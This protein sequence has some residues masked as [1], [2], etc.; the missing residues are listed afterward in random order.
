MIFC[1]TSRPKKSLLAHAQIVFALMRT[2]LDKTIRCVLAAFLVVGTIQW[3]FAGSCEKEQAH[4]LGTHAEAAAPCA[5][6]DHHVVSNGAC[7]Q[8]FCC[9][10]A[11]CGQCVNGVTMLQSAA[12]R[13][14]QD[15]PSVIPTSHQQRFHQQQ[16][17]TVFRPPRPLA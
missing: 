10:S 8:G 6:L 17:K 5:H 12:L 1:E 14:S 13:I 9:Q 11:H 7:Q 16:S 4:T 3:S 15:D 2:L